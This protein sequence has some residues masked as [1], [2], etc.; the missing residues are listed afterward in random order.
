VYGQ[1]HESLRGMPRAML[2]CSLPSTKYLPPSTAMNRLNEDL[3]MLT[4]HHYRCCCCCCCCRAVYRKGVGVPALSRY[5]QEANREVQVWL[6]VRRTTQHTTQTAPAS[7]LLV[8]LHATHIHCCHTQLCCA[9]VHLVH[10]VYS[11]LLA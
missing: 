6:Q 8:L 4:Q 7:T 3:L 2:I 9:C 11:S 1:L 5:L 10:A